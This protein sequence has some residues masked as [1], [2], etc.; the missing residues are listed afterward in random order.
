MA[1][2]ADELDG[3]ERKE[4]GWATTFSVLAETISGKYRDQILGLNKGDQNSI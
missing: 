1:F 2:N 4:N 3:E